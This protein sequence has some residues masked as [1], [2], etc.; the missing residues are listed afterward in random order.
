MEWRRNAFRCFI[1]KKEKTDLLLRR[2]QLS[3]LKL[4]LSNI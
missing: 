4:L 2:F 3:T 1:I